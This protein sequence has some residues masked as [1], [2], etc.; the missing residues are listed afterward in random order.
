MR[1][2]K[3]DS[4]VDV[5]VYDFLLSMPQENVDKILIH[6][7]RTGVFDEILFSMAVSVRHSKGKS[8]YPRK[9][10]IK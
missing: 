8:E 10:S 5:F 6:L 3:T 1:T 9:R 4:F 7:P 2:G